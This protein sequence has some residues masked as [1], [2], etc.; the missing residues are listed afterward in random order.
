M[1]RLP[2]K[3]QWLLDEIRVDDFD[4]AAR[5]DDPPSA[6]H[7]LSMLDSSLR[8]ALIKNQARIGWEKGLLY[9]NL[10]RAVIQF[11]IKP[12][13]FDY[14]F[15][16]RN[17]YRAHFWADIAKGLEFNKNVIEKVRLN[18]ERYLPT[19]HLA[20]ILDKEFYTLGRQQ[21]AKTDILA[22]LDC[23]LAKVWFAG[24]IIDNGQVDVFPGQPSIIFRDSRSS[25][26]GI[27]VTSGETWLDI[28]GAFI[29]QDSLHQPKN[30][31]DRAYELHLR[32]SA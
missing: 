4:R 6:D 27:H 3:D 7:I 13:H 5:L 8:S 28:K 16:S 18:I 19:S 23:E 26:Q 10:P 31:L 9:E 30:P 24:K 12:E 2:S 29:G 1:N 32:G 11:E 20:T 25:W 21:V 14:F 17:G 22:S 15:N